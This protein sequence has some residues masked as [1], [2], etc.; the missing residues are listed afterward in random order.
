MARPGKAR[1]L[2]LAAED[3]AQPRPDLADPGQRLAVCEGA[4]LPEAAHAFD[5]AL[6]Q[7]AILAA[8]SGLTEPAAALATFTETNLR[9]SRIE[10]PGSARVQARLDEAIAA[11]PQ[12]PSEEPLHRGEIIVLIADIETAF[13]QQEAST[14]ATSD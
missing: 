7:L 4:S 9:P 6:R 11:V 5:L 3:D 14:R 2:V 1:D 8:E 12:R 10:N 13:T